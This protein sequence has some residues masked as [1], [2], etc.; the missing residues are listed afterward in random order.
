MVLACYNTSEHV[1]ILRS[2]IIVD[3]DSDILFSDLLMS[4][5]KSATYNDETLFFKD[6]LEMSLST[7]CVIIV[8]VDSTAV[9]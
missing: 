2:Y 5:P 7:F 1:C 8:L 3:V 4:V 9:I 6:M